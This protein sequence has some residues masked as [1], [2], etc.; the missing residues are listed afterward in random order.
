VG[1]P[2]LRLLSPVPGIRIACA[3]RVIT[4][5]TIPNT[6]PVPAP[7]RAATFI[8]LSRN[9]NVTIRSCTCAVGGGWNAYAA[10][11]KIGHFGWCRRSPRVHAG[12]SK[13]RSI[14]I[15]QSALIPLVSYWEHIEPTTT[16]AKGPL[17]AG[18]GLPSIRCADRFGACAFPPIDRASAGLSGGAICKQQQTDNQAAKGGSDTAELRTHSREEK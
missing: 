8:T 13:R 9:S 4:K 5:P 18:A 6:N 10:G 3:C 17:L 16:S 15:V 12:A 14:I 11:G 7:F 1:H 2:A